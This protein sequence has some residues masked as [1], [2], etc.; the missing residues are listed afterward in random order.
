M[1]HVTG[2]QTHSFLEGLL[3]ISSSEV[4]SRAAAKPTDIVILS[5]TL[6]EGIGNRHSDV[7]VYVIGQ[8]Q[9]TVEEIGKRNFT[10]VTGDGRVGQV[11]DYLDD[12]GFGFDVEYF[13]HDDIAGI[14]QKIDALYRR[15]MSSTKILRTRL[16][17]AEDDAIHKLH[18]GTV[19]QGQEAFD[20]LFPPS[21][22]EKC[23]FV[24][25]RNRTGGYPEVKD[26]MGAWVTGD[27][28]T[29][30]LVTQQYLT[31]Q[32]SG[33]FHLYGCSNTKPKWFLSNLK[34]LPEELSDLKRRIRHW[35]LQDKTSDDRIRT[36]IL[37]AC[38]LID[39]IFEAGARA[40]GRSPLYYSAE[41]AA[42]LTDEEY[43]RETFHDAQT[44]LEFAHRRCVFGERRIPMRT[45]LLDDTLATAIAS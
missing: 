14:K 37:E 25:Y 15:A 43:A 42:R 10:G 5:G 36:A 28:D 23:C 24:M 39:E 32:A 41:E 40:L 38:N 19:I 35:F 3:T 16:E 8:E 18:V 7:D 29:C 33:L 9:P 21:V 34:R 2:H 1:T 27:L 4:L 31:E 45:F 13:T 12:G 11:Y 17:R 22:F 20:A 44:Q 26:I 30:L 6:V